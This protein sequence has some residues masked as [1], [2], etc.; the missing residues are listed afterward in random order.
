MP[1]IH[2]LLTAAEPITHMMGIRGNV[3]VL[4]RETVLCDEKPPVS[5]PVLSGNALRHALM[6][7]PAA[8][9]LIDDLGIRSN[10]SFALA[11]M[12]YHGGALTGGKTLNGE[13]IRDFC[14]S[15]P[16]IRLFGGSFPGNIIAGILHV[17]RAILVC[18]ETREAIRRL[19]GFDIGDNAPSCEDCIGEYQYTRGCED[20]DEDDRRMIYTGECVLR[21]SRFYSRVYLEDCASRLEVGCL[22][23]ALRAADHVIGGSGRC[24]HGLLDIRYACDYSADYIDA[25][26]DEYRRNTRENAAGVTDMLNEL[27][28]PAKPVKKAKK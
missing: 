10:V 1:A 18:D 8:N 23:A 7:E 24:G 9:I 14:K 26:I 11:D 17:G 19:S 15:I 28:A 20:V 6:R 12:L 22:F 5:V 13:G 27:F 16:F 4:N 2:L 25:C 21:G 3:A